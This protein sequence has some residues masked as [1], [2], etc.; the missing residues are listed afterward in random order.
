VSKSVDR[1]IK[2]SP[3]SLT[4]KQTDFGVKSVPERQPNKELKERNKERRDVSTCQHGSSVDTG[5]ST[6]ESS[7]DSVF[8]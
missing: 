6:G 7:K 2:E 5:T 3:L 8:T 1:Q 4:L